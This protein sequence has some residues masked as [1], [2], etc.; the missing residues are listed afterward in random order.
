M[1]KTP[2][3]TLEA[4]I[5]VGKNKTALTRKRPGAL[6][7]SAMLAGAFIA[8]GGILALICGNGLTHAADGNPA[9]PRMVSGALFPIGLI[10]VVMTGV[11]LFTGNNAMLI[12]AYMR[13]HAG[14]RDIAINWTLVYIGNTVGAIA[15]A[16]LFVYL[17][18]LIDAEPFAAAAVNIGI[19]KTSM[20]WGVVL[21]KGIGAN[22][23]VCMGVWMALASGSTAGKVLGCWWPV[24]AFVTLGFEHSIANM[25]Y[26]PLSLMAGAP[27]SV[28]TV[29]TA[30]LI[31]ATLG[32]IIGGALFVGGAHY[33]INNNIPK[34]S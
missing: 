25:F 5:Q 13:R 26:L 19:A 18:G 28:S 15:F 10:M 16:W 21:L 34:P 12:P 31:P 2:K 17:P 1:T 29:I 22:W 20:P 14:L 8:V 24:M 30:N 11:E 23:L 33:Y 9:L 32:N 27:I 6:L 7:V 4:A 3:E